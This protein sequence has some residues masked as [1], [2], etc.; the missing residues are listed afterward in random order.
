MGTSTDYSAPP[1]WSDVKRDVTSSSEDGRLEPRDA[2][3]VVSGFVQQLRAS[4]SSGLRSSSRSSASSSTSGRSSGG[5]GV[6]GG[7][8]GR[9]G[10]G[11]GGSRRTFGGG[12]GGVARGLSHFIQET[13]K[14]GLRDALD[15]LGL[16]SIDGKT[17]EEIAFALADAL[18]GP[19]STID[20]VDLRNALA[21][22][23]QKLLG[24]SGT[25]EDLEQAVN[26]AA[27][28]LAQVIRELFG[29]YIY[30]R[31]CSTMYSHLE[32][33]HGSEA[34]D[35]YLS[36]IR[37]YISARMELMAI[38][39]DLK[40]IDWSGQEGTTVV[41]EMLDDTLCVFNGEPT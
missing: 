26:A 29:N 3:K 27:G 36:S 16:S 4:L 32:K 37:E 21:D 18:G 23:V 39:R 24:E 7:G 35:G 6:T 15:A 41:Q 22:L 12:L 19:A 40:S 31:F 17:P 14:R 9:G 13:V 33:K 5:G 34:A 20:Q 25:F 1:E 2:E 11:K 8:G 28:S 38:G 30:Q 10:T